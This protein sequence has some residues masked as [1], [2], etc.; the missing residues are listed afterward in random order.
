AFVPEGGWHAHVEHGKVGGGVGESG[1]QFVAAA[2][3]ADDVDSGLLQQPHEA[4][5]QENGVIRHD[6]SHAVKGI[7]AVT[8]VGPPLG[9]LISSVPPRPWVRSVSPARP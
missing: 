2:V 1:E 9:L 4:F 8:V 3:C 5:T 7:F 6:Y